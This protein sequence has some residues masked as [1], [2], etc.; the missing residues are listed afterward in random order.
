MFH[1]LLPEICAAEDPDTPYWPS[2]PSS[3]TPFVNPDSIRTGDTHNWAVWHGNKPFE[4]YREH[5]SR[6]VSEFGFQSLPCLDTVRTYADEADWN[7]TSYI[8]EHHQRNEA[9]NGKII[10]YMTDHF[11]MPKDFPSLVY[12]TQVLQAEC[13]RTGVEYWRRNRHRTSGALYWQLNDCWPVASWASLDY[14]GRWKALHYAARRFNAPVMLSAEL[15]GPQKDAEST[16]RVR[17][18]WALET[19]EGEP[20]GDGVRFVEM[21]IAYNLLGSRRHATEEW[22]PEITLFLTNDTP[23]EQQGTIRWSLEALDGKVLTDGEEAVAV[24]ALSAA[25]VYTLDFSE[26][27]TTQNRRQVVLVYELWQEDER[28]SLDVVPFVPDKHLELADPE[29]HYTI[30]E[31]DEAITIDVTAQRLARFVW[32]EIE[33]A[34]VVFSDN[35]FALPAGRT[36]KVTLPKIEGWTLDRARQALRVRS[37]VDSF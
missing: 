16:D 2:S 20:L 13:V 10:N 25:Q 17:L 23:D 19:A 24:P 22:K 29:L 28:I 26:Q 34:D 12:V 15:G 3:N 8:M 5:D 1:H 11:R 32:L 36:A 37:L 33:G 9:G 35:Y 7:M 14:F 6:F 21:E 31:T 4:A 18:N 30:G 27:V